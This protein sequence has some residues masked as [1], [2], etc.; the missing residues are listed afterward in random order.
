M[1][2]YIPAGD[3]CPF[4]TFK[5]VAMQNMYDNAMG[6]T[7]G[8][9]TFYYDGGKFLGWGGG[10]NGFTPMYGTNV[11]TGFNSK[12]DFG[13]W[14]DWVSATMGYSL[15]GGQGDL[16]KIS[17]NGSQF[18]VLRPD[19][20][21][22]YSFMWFDN[23]SKEDYGPYCPKGPDYVGLSFNGNMILGGGYGGTLSLWF[24]PGDG[25]FVNGT[26]RGGS[27][28]DFLTLGLTLEFGYNTSGRQLTGNDFSGASTWQSTDLWWLTLDASQSISEKGIGEVYSGFGLGVGFPP[29]FGG[30]GGAGYTTSPLYLLKFK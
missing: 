30:S 15:P 2:I 24:M 26:G 5:G 20:K 1:Y 4:Q 16:I 8:H 9:V 6:I 17:V 29:G 18:T 3:L 28:L 14:R 21:N 12:G 25:I 22:E 27:G 10:P 19:A 7:D 11:N 13:Y 23:D